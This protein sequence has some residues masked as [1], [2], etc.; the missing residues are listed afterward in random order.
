MNPLEITVLVLILLALL[1]I[2]GALLAFL[3]WGLGW[4]VIPGLAIAGGLAF[5]FAE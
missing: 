3:I 5:L 2:L 4:L 1:P